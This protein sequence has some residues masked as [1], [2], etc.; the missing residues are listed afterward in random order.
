MKQNL[1]AP[2]QIYELL[3]TW[4]YGKASAYYEPFKNEIHILKGK[5]LEFRA[6][7]HEVYHSQR[8]G[9]LTFQLGALMQIPQVTNLFFGLFIALGAFG[10]G[11]LFLNPASWL[12]LVPSLFVAALFSGLL[13]CLAYEE[14]LA[15]QAVVQ[16]C[17]AIKQNGAEQ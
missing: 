5:D 12:M 4:R 2:K 8:R 13:G 1:E 6:L 11:N 15:D 10:V 7:A 3:E 14:Y 9:K 16:C 17:K